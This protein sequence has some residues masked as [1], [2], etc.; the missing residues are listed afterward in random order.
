MATATT[1]ETLPLEIARFGSDCTGLITTLDRIWR[2]VRKGCQ[3]YINSTCL[4]H[5]TENVTGKNN[6]FLSWYL[7]FD[8]KDLAV[9]AA[10]CRAPL[11][12]VGGTDR[13]KTAFAQLALNALFGAHGEQWWKIEISRGMTL[14]DFIDIN[15]KKLNESSL[16]EAVSASAWLAFPGVLLDEINRAHPMLT[17]QLL[18]IVDGK[19]LHARA[20]LHLP[21]GRPYTIDGKSKRYSVTLATANKR[22][23]EEDPYAGVFMMDAALVR[24]LV[25]FIDLD[26]V[27]PSYQDTVKLAR[28]CRPELDVPMCTSLLEPIVRIYE[29]LPETVPMSPLGELYVQYLSG[30]GNCIR[31]RSGRQ[32]LTRQ[33]SICAGCHLQKSHKSC[34]RLAGVTE[35]LLLWIKEIARG[36][37]ALRAVKVLDYVRNDCAQQRIA[38]VQ[39][40][41]GISAKGDA[42]FEAFRESYLERLA[43]KGEDVVAAYSLVAPNHVSIIDPAWLESQENYEHSETYAFADVAHTGWNALQSL[44]RQHA[45]LFEEVASGREL[46]ADNQSALEALITT[47]DP[48]LLSVVSGLADREVPMKFREVLGRGAQPVGALAST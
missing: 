7:G 3:D 48:A 23:K 29:S 38:D 8:L 27:P 14:D 39:N 41:L 42:L 4:V 26:E 19:G 16:S 40:F 44:L 28:Q 2:Q 37:A 30:M 24:R 31:T 36:I 18:H 43:V 35:G 5:V 15:F 9:L 12:F 1:Q 45:P 20:D 25:L 6:T 22:E 11:A 34:S 21:M 33:A 17:N 46:S 47:V 10:I 13:G 32:H